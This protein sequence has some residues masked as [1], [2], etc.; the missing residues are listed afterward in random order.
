MVA[1]CLHKIISV[2]I[3]SVMY[4]D[5]LGSILI[6]ECLNA[7]FEIPIFVSTFLDL[8]VAFELH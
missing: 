5:F 3:I 1:S 6:I 7:C 8:I 4:N 2:Q